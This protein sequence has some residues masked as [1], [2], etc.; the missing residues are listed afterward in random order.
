MRECESSPVLGV[1]LHPER[2]MRGREEVEDKA[3][4]V[5]CGHANRRVEVHARL[6]LI[7]PDQQGKGK[8]DAVLDGSGR[9]AHDAEADDLSESLSLT[10]P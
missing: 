3:D 2:V 9:D 6:R 5:P 7:V 1:C 4:D 10:F 8:I